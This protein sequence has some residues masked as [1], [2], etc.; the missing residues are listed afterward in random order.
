MTCASATCWLVL[1][2]ASCAGLFADHQSRDKPI[3]YVAEC[4]SG[5]VVPFVWLRLVK[6]YSEGVVLT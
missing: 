3:N 1:M 2:S 4:L 5:T 6:I